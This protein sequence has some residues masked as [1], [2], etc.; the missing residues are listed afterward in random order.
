MSYTYL[1]RAKLNR[2]LGNEKRNMTWELD[3]IMTVICNRIRS[4]VFCY[5]LRYHI[6]TNIYLVLNEDTIKYCDVI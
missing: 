2:L 4:D 1:W 6:K 5:T 3:N